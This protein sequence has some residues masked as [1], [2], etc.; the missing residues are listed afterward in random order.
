MDEHRLPELLRD[1]PEFLEAR[2]VDQDVPGAAVQHD[3]DEAECCG[4]LQFD[5]GGVRVGERQG[6]E[7][8]EAIR[9]CGDRGRDL[10]V[11]IA[12][13]GDRVDR[14]EPLRARRGEGQDLH[15][16]ALCVHRGEALALDVAEAPRGIAVVVEDEA[17][18]A[19]ISRQ[20]T[21]RTVD[22]LVH[23]VLL[24]PDQQI[25]HG[26]VLSLTPCRVNRTADVGDHLR[27]VLWARCGA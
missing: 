12:A 21:L 26:V 27:T 4:A 24:D 5:G 16:D 11:R 13:Q 17:V 9:V 1:G 20:C 3:A 7:G 2:V 6:R 25:R 22:P 18:V 19:P 10:V 8:P 14:V 23:P 15:V